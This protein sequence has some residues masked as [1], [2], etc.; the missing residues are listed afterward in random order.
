MLSEAKEISFCEPIPEQPLWVNA[1][2]HA[3][4]RLFLILVDN[5]IKYTPEHGR[6]EIVVGQEN[7]LAIGEV[8]DTGIG[9]APIMPALVNREVSAWG[10]RLGAGSPRLMKGRL[11]FRVLSAGARYLNYDFLW[12][13]ESRRS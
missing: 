7:G 4:R 6:V 5:V 3:L 8:R 11:R 12:S 13:M 1:D 10:S 2:A 9:I